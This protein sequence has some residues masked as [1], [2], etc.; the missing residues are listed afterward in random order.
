MGN[1]DVRKLKFCNQRA[2][3]GNLP[4]RKVLRKKNKRLQSK[5]VSSETAI[6]EMEGAI[7]NTLLRVVV[8]ISGCCGDENDMGVYGDCETLQFRV[9]R[10]GFE[11]RKENMEIKRIVADFEEEKGLIQLAAKWE[12]MENPQC[13]I[14]K[15][16][17]EIEK[18]V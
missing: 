6:S 4:I 11:R 9:R 2:I 13:K 12:G 7:R 10:R 8:T 14:R 17:K 15:L 18:G 1:Y 16:K 3:L 5:M